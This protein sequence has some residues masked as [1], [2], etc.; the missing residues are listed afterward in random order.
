MIDKFYRA[1]SEAELYDIIPANMK[2][3]DEDGLEVLA[4]ATTQWAWDWNIP[5]VITPAVFDETDID[6]VITQA[7]MSTDFHANL[8]LLDETVDVSALDILEVFPVT[9]DRIFA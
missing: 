3:L 5:H 7:V 6:L 8:R 4:S 9:P 1:T 2:I